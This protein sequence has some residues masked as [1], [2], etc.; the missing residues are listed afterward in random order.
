MNVDLQ[1][2][3]GD[4]AMSFF[5]GLFLLPY[6]VSSGEWRIMERYPDLINKT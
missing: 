5:V 1:H 6:G 3:G 2:L 4:Q